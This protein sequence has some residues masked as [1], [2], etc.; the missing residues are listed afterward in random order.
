MLWREGGNHSESMLHSTQQCLR[1]MKTA[2]LL[3]ELAD[4]FL[5][6]APKEKSYNCRWSADNP[7]PAVA[8]QQCTLKVLAD[9]GQVALS[10]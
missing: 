4:T 10:H 7:S 6:Q 5:H 8:V 2:I 3:L 1:H 9:R